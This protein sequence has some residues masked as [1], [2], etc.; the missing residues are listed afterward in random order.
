M[1]I[2]SVSSSPSPPSPP[3]STPTQDASYYRTQD[4][5]SQQKTYEASAYDNN[6]SY[7]SGDEHAADQQAQRAP[8]PPGQGTRVDILV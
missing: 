5:S 2:S 6:K 1:S 8:L 7:K 3:P 4:T